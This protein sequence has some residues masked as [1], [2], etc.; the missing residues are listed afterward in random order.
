MQEHH[1]VAQGLN[2]NHDI[3]QQKGESI[4]KFVTRL[5]LAAQKCKLGDSEN[6]RIIDYMIFG[7]NNYRVRRE[8]MGKDE[9]LTLDDA[10]TAARLVEASSRSI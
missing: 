4:D 9:K 8:L 5:K 6:D 10:I 7:V 2:Y 3:K 1:L